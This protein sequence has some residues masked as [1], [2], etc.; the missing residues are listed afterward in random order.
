[1]ELLTSEKKKY[2]IREYKTFKERSEFCFDENFCDIG[3]GDLSS[4]VVANEMVRESKF[5]MPIMDSSHRRYLAP[6][7]VGLKNF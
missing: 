2:L 3:F 6:I 1:M 5:Y 7:V 4:A